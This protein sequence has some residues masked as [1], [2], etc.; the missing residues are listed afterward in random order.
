MFIDGLVLAGRK[1]LEANIPGLPGE[2]YCLFTPNLA[3]VAAIFCIKRDSLA[4]AFGF[5]EVE[6]GLK[7]LVP[8]VL[9]PEEKFVPIML[10]LTASPESIDPPPFENLPRILFDYGYRAYA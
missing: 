4:C 6:L 3:L 8:V 7:N 5:G 9:G 2:V 1:L 10:L